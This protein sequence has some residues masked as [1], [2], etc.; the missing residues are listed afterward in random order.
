MVGCR[1]VSAGCEH[2]YAERMA[3][4]LAAMGRP[5]YQGLLT[6][7]GRWNGTVRCL[8]ERLSIPAHWKKPRRI[9][10]DSMSDLFHEDV[11]LD[12]IQKVFDI[13]SCANLHTFQ[14]LSKRAERLLE[15]DPLIDWPQNVWMGVSVENKDYISRIDM[16]RQTHAA[17][18]FLSCEPLIGPLTNL[19]L[20]GIDWIIVGGESGPKARPM[21]PN[22]VR[23][24]RDQ[25]LRTGITFYFKQWGEWYPS[26]LQGSEADYDRYSYDPKTDTIRIG[27]KL[28]GRI[29]DC[30]KWDQYPEVR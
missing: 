11:P 29:L 16:L 5:E 10:V 24:L 26:P 4:R 7:D 19:H 12:F 27:K 1:R 2:C 30:R 6:N 18:K 22:W 25:C 8:P 3:R 14:I 9:F 13:M 28:A 20:E 15:L 23:S 21:H 17:V